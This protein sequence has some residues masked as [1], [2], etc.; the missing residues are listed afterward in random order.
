MCQIVIYGKYYM[1]VM[2][3]D[4]FHKNVLKLKSFTIGIL[5]GKLVEYSSVYT[6]LKLIA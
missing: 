4:K 6:V 2:E 3:V 5:K 1:Y